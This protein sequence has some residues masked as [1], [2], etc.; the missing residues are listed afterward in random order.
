ML[1]TPDIVNKPDINSKTKVNVELI[2]IEIDNRDS[3]ALESCLDRHYAA[4]IARHSPAI[5]VA[6]H[7]PLISVRRRP[8]R[9]Y[10]TCSC[11]VAVYVE[12]RLH[13]VSMI[14]FV[15]VL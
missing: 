10:I 2:F 13:N 14:N 1:I 5:L 7:T 12:R 6:C 9:M 8:S 11:H 15:Q 4:F 3:Q